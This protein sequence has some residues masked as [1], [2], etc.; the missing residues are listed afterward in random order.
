[1]AT[2]TG[3]WIRSDFED[4]GEVLFFFHNSSGGGDAYI[5]MYADGS[6]E[7]KGDRKIVIKN[8][9]KKVVI[10]NAADLVV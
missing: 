6:V 2:K 3:Q 9:G 1:M 4:E 7:F 5:V 8:S 10:E